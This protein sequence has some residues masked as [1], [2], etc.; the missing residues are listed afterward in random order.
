MAFGFF[1]NMEKLSLGIAKKYAKKLTNNNY[2]LELEFEPPC[3]DEDNLLPNMEYGFIVI[4]QLC[5]FVESFLNT[6]LNACMNYSGDKL[7]RCS[8]E[9]KIDIIF[10][11]YQQDFSEIKGSY[12]Y[13]T[14][15]KVTKIR[16]EMTHFKKTYVGDGSQTPNFSIK[17]EKIG[18]FFTQKS[19]CEYC[20]N[21]EKLCEMI[22]QKLNLGINNSVDIIECDGRDE[23]VNY[24]YDPV[25]TDI[26]PSRFEE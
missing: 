6:I 24:I 26:D 5:C 1:F 9:E 14:F 17:G 18:D 8:I 25:N 19:M 12:E 11:H 10:L 4:T 3:I 7:L 13:E 20:D 23:L 2:L 21:V 22:A 15:R 16:N